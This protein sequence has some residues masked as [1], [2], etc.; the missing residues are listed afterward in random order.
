MT[1]KLWSFENHVSVIALHCWDWIIWV[2]LYHGAPDT[3]NRL[4]TAQLAMARVL[5]ISQVSWAGQCSRHNLTW[6][7]EWGT[8]GLV[9]GVLQPDLSEFCMWGVRGPD[10]PNNVFPFLLL[11]HLYLYLRSHVGKRDWQGIDSILESNL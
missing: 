10:L 1:L 6:K 5:C 9:C 11:S 3:S 7:R 2:M 4:D 8:S